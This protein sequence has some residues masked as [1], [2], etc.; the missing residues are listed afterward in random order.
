MIVITQAAT[1]SKF[2]PPLIHRV[3][4]LRAQP[5]CAETERT[6][7]VSIEGE[8]ARVMGALLDGSNPVSILRSAMQE[9]LSKTN[10]LNVPLRG[11]ELYELRLDDSE[12]IWNPGYIVRE[13]HAMW[14]EEC[15]DV[16]WDEVETERHATLEEAKARYEARRT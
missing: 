1:D 8:H 6:A 5:L 12:D 2:T 3:E 15:G 9:L 10:G 11:L 7:S 13:A 16:V 14:H 4:F